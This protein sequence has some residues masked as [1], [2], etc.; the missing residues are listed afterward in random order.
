MVARGGEMMDGWTYCKDERVH[1]ICVCRQ[2]YVQV[3][4]STV[5]A[6]RPARACDPQPITAGSGKCNLGLYEAVMYVLQ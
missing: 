1:D 3:L 2:A 6:Y 4:P 5:S